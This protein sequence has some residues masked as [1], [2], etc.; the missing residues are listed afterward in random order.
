MVDLGLIPDLERAKRAMWS[1]VLPREQFNILFPEEQEQVAKPDP[2]SI[3]EM[4]QMKEKVADYAFMPGEQEG[5]SGIGTKLFKPVRKWN[6]NVH[7]SKKALVK[8]YLAWRNRFS[9]NEKYTTP[10]QRRQ[11]DIMWDEWMS[12]ANAFGVTEGVGA[13]KKTVATKAFQDWNPEDSDIHALRGGKLESAYN[14]VD[15]TPMNPSDRANPIQSSIAKELPKPKAASG[16]VGVVSPEG[17]TGLIPA[18]RLQDYL[19]NGYKRA[20]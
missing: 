14:R 10:A 20:Q 6:A 15:R 19:K 8:Q 11:L 9:Y 2:F 3:S 16:K 7:Y 13:K 1:A 12:E 17:R 4:D 5:Q 18:A